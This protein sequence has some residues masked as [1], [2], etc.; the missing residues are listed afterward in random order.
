MI[1]NKDRIVRLTNYR[2]I[3][4]TLL[5]NRINEFGNLAYSQEGEDRILFSLIGHKLKGFYVDIGAHHPQRFSNTNLFY[6]MGWKGINID[7]DKDL[8]ELLNKIRPR[9]LNICA[10][11]GLVEGKKDFIVFEEPA[12]N[13][14]MKINA[15]ENLKK[16]RYKSKRVIKISKL[17]TL[18]DK[19][20]PNDSKIDILNVDVE[21]MDYEVLKSNNWSKYRPSIIVVEIYGGKTFN[22]I[23]NDK[24]THYLSK[25]KYSPIA[26]TIN[27]VIFK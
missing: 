5:Y 26:K 10:G 19:H 15:K 21:G 13:T 25:F 7:A 27:T 1:I 14:F 24:I 17:S 8:V 12:F 3:L 16:S 11:V 22:D 23:N 18:L 9:D 20:L 2:Y 4:N 6:N